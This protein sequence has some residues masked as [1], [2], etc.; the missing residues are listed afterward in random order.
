MHGKTSPVRH[1]GTGLFAGLPDPLTATRYHSLVISRDDVPDSLRVNA[2]A[3]DGDIMGVT[4]LE[5]PVHGV[6]FHPESVLTEYGYAMLERFLRGDTA[7]SNLPSSA[8]DLPA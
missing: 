1:D 5:H 6:Q 8:D 7:R 3:P 2:V 4:H